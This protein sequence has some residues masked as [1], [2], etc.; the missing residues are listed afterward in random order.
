MESLSIQFHLHANEANNKTCSL[1]AW[2]VAST[3][4]C[5]LNSA[6]ACCSFMTARSRSCCSRVLDSVSERQSS[7]TCCCMLSTAASA[8]LSFFVFC[9]AKQSPASQLTADIWKKEIKKT[10]SKYLC[11]HSKQSATSNLACIAN[12]LI[13]YIKKKLSPSR[14]YY[15]PP[16]LCQSRR[17]LADPWNLSCFAFEPLSAL[18]LQSVDLNPLD[19]LQGHLSHLGKIPKKCRE[20]EDSSY[21]CMTAP[22]RVTRG[23]CCKVSEN[24][25]HTNEFWCI[26]LII[27]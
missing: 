10:D 25:H 16:G 11:L 15:I 23:H 9:R 24:P 19:L 13:I 12:Y 22:I 14:T 17:L 3:F 2:Q 8:T 6:A 20:A 18:P 1:R 4:C 7:T 21:S 27:H 26:S 5:S